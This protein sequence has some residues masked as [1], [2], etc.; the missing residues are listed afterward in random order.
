MK[1]QSRA[2]YIRRQED[3]IVWLQNEELCA[4]PRRVNSASRTQRVAWEERGNERTGWHVYVPIAEAL[5]PDNPQ[6]S[7]FRE[8]NMWLNAC[9]ST[10]STGLVLGGWLQARL[11]LCISLTPCRSV[12]GWVCLCACE[13]IHSVQWLFEELSTETGFPQTIITNT[14]ETSV[15]LSW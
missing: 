11:P 12:C 15:F 5:V 10:R 1:L 4:L 6:M 3:S 13:G 8:A 14:P 2:Y 9:H 7:D